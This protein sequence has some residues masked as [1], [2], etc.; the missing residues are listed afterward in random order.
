MEDIN[1][2]ES[3]IYLTSTQKIPIEIASNSYKSFDKGLEPKSAKEYANA[4][5]ILNSGRLLFNSYNDGILLTANNSINLNSQESVNI[6]ADDGVSVA[7]GKDSEITLGSNDFSVIEP[8]ILGDKFLSD[9]ERLANILVS[10]GTNFELNP[11]LVETNE[12][13][14]ELL[15]IGGDIRNAAQNILNNIEN[16]K[17]KVTYSK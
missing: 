11:M 14:N 5:I 16:Y 13:N 9:I 6:D 7:V 8:I 3:S 10:L 17:S 2:D 12:S 4:Q 1:K 15:N